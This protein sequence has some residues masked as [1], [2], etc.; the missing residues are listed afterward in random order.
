MLPNLID[1]ISVNFRDIQLFGLRFLLRH[2]SRLT[3]AQTT[4]V[5]VPGF[6]DIHVRIGESDVAVVRQVF[7]NKDYEMGRNSPIEAR[8]W[9][10]YSEI[11]KLGKA[12]IIVDAGANIGA[13]SLWFHKKY[14]L[15]KVVAIEPEPGNLQ[16]LAKNA[17]GTERI[18]V[19]PA[20]IGATR[21]FVS[22]KNATFGWAA[23]TAR[24]DNGVQV[25]T[26]ADAFKMVDGIP[27]IAKI[28]IE[29]F[30]NDLF[31]ANTDWLKDVF[32]VYIEPHDWL[33]PGKLTSQT[34]QRA[35]GQHEFEIF[36]VGENLAFVRV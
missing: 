1:R 31:Q 11:A 8:I 25:V 28:D 14:P 20:A 27:F 29:G 36:I 35:M 30:E 9:N 7:G 32:V 26:M 4:T 15:A 23:T 17:E 2:A 21:G 18:I 12:P 19:L 16:I 3:G 34:F 6:G 13:A 33:F 24:S 22:I 5:P 10:R